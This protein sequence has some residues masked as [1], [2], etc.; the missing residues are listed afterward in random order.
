MQTERLIEGGSEKSTG[1]IENLSGEVSTLEA[2][3]QALLPQREP[4]LFVSEL[5]YADK[6]EII[7]TMIYGEAFPYY[8]PC[9]PLRK[10]V[11]GVILIESIVQ[12][13][14]A[15]VSKAGIFGN[16]PWGL[17]AIEKAVFRGVVEPN[18]TIKMVVKN[19]KVSSK[20]LKQ[21]GV[22]Y[23]K[24]KAILKAS[25]FCLPFAMS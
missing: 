5:L 20:I 4:F 16:I 3:I 22:S 11:P 25:W 19:L 8:L 21:S 10:I 12:C 7:G 1:A 18:T 14:G 17:A 13:G 9:S 24:E 2:N 23:Y 6:D 15:G